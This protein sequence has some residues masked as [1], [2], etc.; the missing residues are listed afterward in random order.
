MDILQLFILLLPSII[1][2]SNQ[3]YAISYDHNNDNSA[4]HLTPKA[5]I[6][7]LVEK[8]SLDRASSN[9]IILDRPTTHLMRLFL[10]NFHLTVIQS[11]CWHDSAMSV[12]MIRCRRS[13]F[14]EQW[15]VV[16]TEKRKTS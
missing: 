6:G 9:A 8:D 4:L 10:T 7:N 12:V 11:W 5:I 3:F 15:M 2:V 13:Y 16:V 1:A 14:E